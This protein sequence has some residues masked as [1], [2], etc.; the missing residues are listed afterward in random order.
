[1]LFVLSER[2]MQ[3]LLQ[4][5]VFTFELGNEFSNNAVGKDNFTVF[6]LIYGIVDRIE[7]EID[8]GLLSLNPDE[9]QNEFGFADMV[10]LSKFKMLGGGGLLV[11]MK[12][13]LKSH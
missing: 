5:D 13:F 11:I 8:L 6:G 10:L 3:E 7:V 9:G 2:R 12:I 1:M 4:K